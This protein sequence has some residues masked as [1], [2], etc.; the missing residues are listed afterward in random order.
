MLVTC[1]GALNQN[2]NIDV[3]S[4]QIT[5]F[6]SHLTQD[7]LQSIT[8]HVYKSTCIK[9]GHMEENPSCVQKVSFFPKWIKAKG[10]TTMIEAPMHHLKHAI[11]KTEWM[12]KVRHNHPCPPSFTFE[13][14]WP[15]P[16]SEQ[17]YFILPPNNPNTFPI[18]N[19]RYPMKEPRLSSQ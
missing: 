18:N 9:I 15:S 14:V 2:L 17:T 6:R 4:P 11:C 8:W 12:N 16:F 10:I 13:H 1:H 3:L 7:M 19:G 5:L